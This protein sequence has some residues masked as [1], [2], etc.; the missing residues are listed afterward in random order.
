MDF[1]DFSVNAHI[2]LRD[3]DD[4]WT[5]GKWIYKALNYIKKVFFSGTSLCMQ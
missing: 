5:S 1:F 4:T 2:L 3:E